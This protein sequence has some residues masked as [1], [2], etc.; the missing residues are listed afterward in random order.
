MQKDE[1]KDKCIAMSRHAVGLDHNEPYKR[2]G[3]LYYKPHRNYYDAS[4]E[5]CKYW[6]LLVD[7]G[8][9][10]TVGTEDRLGGKMYELTRKGL[11]WLGEKLGV[12][13]HDEDE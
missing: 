6:D 8:F 9:A 2:Y 5:D 11:D 13:I 4:P 7:K 10:K 1:Y 3:R 12:H